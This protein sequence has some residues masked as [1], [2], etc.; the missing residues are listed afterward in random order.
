MDIHGTS[1]YFF[2]ST[3]NIFSSRFHQPS[4]ICRPAARGIGFAGEDVAAFD[5]Q[6]HQRAGGS[7]T[8]AAVSGDDQ[9]GIGYLRW[10]LPVGCQ[11]CFIKP[12]NYT[13]IVIRC[14]KFNISYKML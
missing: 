10:G 11:R 2:V 9:P 8:T 14:Y 7:D 4:K 3:S 1:W 13:Y 5:A 12:I 6:L